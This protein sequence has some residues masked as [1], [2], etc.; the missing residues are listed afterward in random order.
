VADYQ[1]GLY[2]HF[3]HYHHHMLGYAN[4]R[5]T[6]LGADEWT[7]KMGFLFRQ[8]SIWVMA[9]HKIRRNRRMK[10]RV[11]LARL[12]SSFLFSTM[13]DVILSSRLISQRESGFLFF[14]WGACPL[15]PVPCFMQ[16][17]RRRALIQI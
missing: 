17:G 6:L 9:E 4:L 11:R 2:F 14:S 16:I 5:C 13:R 15:P 1:A 10:W 12:L 8:T 7:A 3:Y